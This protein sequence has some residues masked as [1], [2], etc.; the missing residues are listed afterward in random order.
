MTRY[1]RA[2]LLSLAAVCLTPVA[3]QAQTK[4]L[5]F[6]DIHDDRV[7]FSYGGD[8]WYAPAD[9]GTAV[10]LTSHP[11]LELF[12]KFSPDGRKVAFTGQY[13][14][15]EQ[16]YVV[17]GA[18]GVPQQLTWYPAR[19]PLP[20]RW[21]YDN[22]VYGWTPDGQAVLFRS[23]R[24]AEQSAGSRLYTVA[25]DGGLPVPLPMPESG[26]GTYAG[27]ADT[28]F[29]S[30]LFRDFRTWKRYEGGWAQ[31]LWLFDAES[32][33]GRPVIEHPR[34]DR[35]PMWIDGKGYFV[36]DRDGTLNLYRWDPDSDQIEQ[37][38]RHD[39]WDVRWASAGGNGRIVYEHN[40]EL[41]IYD[42]RNGED[43]GI[44]IR[45]PD[46][47]VNRRSR[48]VDVSDQ[49]TGAAISPTGVR[50]LLVARGDVYSVPVED[51]L[52]RNLT[53][54]SDAHEREADW[55][56]DGESIA[57]ISD[58]EGEEGLYVM[59][60]DGSGPTRRLTPDMET[61]LYR[62]LWSPDGEH[63]A[64]SDKDGIIYVFPAAGGAPERVA[65]DPAWRNRD[66]TW[67]PDSRYLAFSLTRDSGMRA[68]H[69]HD[70]EEGESRPIT[71][72]LFSEYQPVF[73]PDGEYLY[74]LGDREFAPQISGHEWNFATNRSTRILGLGLQTD[75]EHPLAPENPGDP[76][77]SG[78]EKDDNGDSGGSDNDADTVI[79]FD[80]L[81]GRVFT[82]PVEPGN[83]SDLWAVEGALL[84]IEQS[85]WYYGRGPVT[86]PRL[87]LFKFE[88]RESD[89][90]VSKINGAA[91]T[92][93]GK[94]V[95]VNQGGKFQVYELAKEGK[96]AKT[97]STSGL[98][99]RIDPAE[100]WGTIFDE[101]WRRFRDHFYVENMH[102]YDWEAIG[103]RY[104][105]WLPHVAHRADLNYVLGEMIAELNVSHAYV[106]G[107]DMGLPE[108]HPTALLG[109]RFELD[110]ESNRYRISRIFE[111][112]NDEPRYHSPLARAGVDVAVGD[113]ILAVNGRPLTG[114]DN[115]FEVLQLPVD[116]PLELRV[117]DR[118]DE[119]EPR[120]VLVE[121]VTD[122]QPLLY[123]DWVLSNYR[124]VR[125]ATDGR[126][127]YL[128]IP[129]MGAD[130]IREFIKWFYG[131]LDTEG[132]I[133]DVRGNGGGNV[134]Q[135][136]IERLARK[137]LALGFS[138]TTPDASTYPYQAYNGHLVALLN[139]TSASDGDIFPYQFRNADLGPLIGKRSWGGVVGISN[140]GPVIDGGLVFVPEYGYADT[141]GEYVIEGRGVAP[142]IEVENTPGALLEGRDP[143]LE[144]GVREIMQRVEADS[145]VLP[146]KP[147]EPV[148]TD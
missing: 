120:T 11:G 109:A 80:G 82:V 3:A 122:E 18:G 123:L 23:H 35:D 29:Y 85:A 148:K 76:G 127:G 145:R 137:P 9:G 93:D 50:A 21:G 136:I 55:S 57:Y 14:G 143:Q 40:G 111:G 45:V 16:V 2:C 48:R 106:Q 79:D 103:E 26:A 118:P 20:P 95:L 63:I 4:L 73:S 128:H 61:R 110:D 43:I 75:G 114:D 56:P 81:A 10:R 129:D 105:R 27:D 119:R 78:G 146:D 99:T 121:P 32:G 54:S 39:D 100:E 13:G 34:T 17:S 65:R 134:S 96:D 42:T 126:V 31:D 94:K 24:D 124:Q 30:P 36:S 46:D 22:Q 138:R 107:G 97:V 64:V 140:H 49:V 70:L 86:Q 51:G 7:V 68:L 87:K 15:D 88:S 116:Q 108:R 5:R 83:L 113:Y 77:A 69:I 139:E 6:P 25:T 101:V 133:I 12:P 28:V 59:P 37:L 41:R 90:F 8:I 53:T 1:M 135:M 112:Q 38:T 60:A 58:A 47:Q 44:R 71:Q 132:L 115:P 131:Q 66:Y 62:P 72:G 117:A 52:T 141:D 74:F 19:G 92:V 98:E 104:R 125:E 102:G 91:V 130:G 144:R 67:S 89:T 142:D 84:Y 147:A 33:E